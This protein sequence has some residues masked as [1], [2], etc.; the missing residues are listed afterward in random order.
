V[1]DKT[2]IYE[3]EMEKPVETPPHRVVSLVPSVTESLFELGVGDRLV[4]VTDY[5]VYPADKVARLPRIG[6]TKNPDVKRIIE[7]SPDLVIANREENRKEDVEALQAARIPVW[8]TF[9]RTV[10]E[11]FNLLWTIMHVFDE[12]K[13]VEGVRAMEWTCDWLERASETREPPC[14][15][16][17]P[18][19]HEPLM[20]FN[21][22]TFAH[23]LLRVC[24]AVNVFAERERKIPL[25]ADLGQA[26]PYPEDDPRAFGRDTRYPRVTLAEVE[27]AQPDMIL[28]PSEPFAFNETHIPIFAALDVP[29][30]RNNAIL[31]ID[32][33]LL[34]WHGTRMARAFD[35]LPRLLCP[36]EEEHAP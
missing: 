14:R 2:Y 13:M 34:T 12:P 33:S 22:D 6:G 35:V 28:L 29:A 31:L 26:E 17:V 5:C 23:D 19:W 20:T 3:Y 1:D 11:A 16:F 27:A 36:P 32:G 24:G 9:P 8:V 18:I 7:L 10:R 30:V 21:A 4:A 25:K 15:V